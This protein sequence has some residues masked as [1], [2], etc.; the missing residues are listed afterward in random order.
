MTTMSAIVIITRS[1]ATAEIEH[2]ADE[3]VIQGH[4]MSSVV[5]PMN[6]A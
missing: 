3:T 5:V 6:A 4:S 2:D 1:S